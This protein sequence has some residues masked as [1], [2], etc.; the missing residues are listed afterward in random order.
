M[1]E[2]YDP[3]GLIRDAF[4]IEGIGAPECRSIFLD[5]A[6]GVPQQF[7]MRDEV[8]KLITLFEGEH[9]ADHPMLVTL[10]EALHDAGTPRRKGGRKSRLERPTS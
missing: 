9:Q 4:A 6:L 3:K 10:S 5:W 1:T 7:D 8:R 2:V